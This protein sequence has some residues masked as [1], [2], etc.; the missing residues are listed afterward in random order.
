M[1]L[2]YVLMRGWF[3]ANLKGS[4]KL[5]GSDKKGDSDEQAMKAPLTAH[6]HFKERRSLAVASP[7]DVS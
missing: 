3:K 1:S 2:W 6:M 4:Q 5:E 7:P